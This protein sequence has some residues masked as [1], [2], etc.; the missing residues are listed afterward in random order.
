MNRAEYLGDSL[1]A[2]DEGFQI[3]LFTSNG[4][5]VDQRVYLEDTVLD[6]FFRFVEFNRK[7]KITVEKISEPA[8]EADPVDL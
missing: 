7:V 2:Q 1:Y 3:T 4:I 6:N 8:T 5:G